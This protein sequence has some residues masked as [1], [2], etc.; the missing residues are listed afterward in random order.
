MASQIKTLCI[1]TVLVAFFAST[2]SAATILVFDQT[3]DSGTVAHAVGGVV[4]GTNIGFNTVTITGAPIAGAN[5]LWIC[6]AC[7]LNFTSG[8]LITEGGPSSTDDWEW[9]PVGST[10]TVTGAIGGLGI[11]NV[12]L[13]S[14]RFVT[15]IDGENLFTS[16]EVDGFG[17]DE[18]HE[19]LL[20]AL[21]IT[22]ADFIFA[23]NTISAQ[24]AI[25][26]DGSFTGNVTNADLTNTAPV[27]GTSLLM[28]LGL[29]G[30]TL[31][32]RKR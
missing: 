8:P 21:G 16:L 30:I 4:T 5:N 27:P 2:A 25:N 18:K 12:T 19:L 11:P 17:F 31:V 1:V 14:G 29:A 13:L 22:N 32:R 15:N 23:D 10:F 24:A 26:A 9:S 6:T 7:F 3:A 28:L 20:A